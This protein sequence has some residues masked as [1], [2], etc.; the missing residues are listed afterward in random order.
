MTRRVVIDTDPGIDDAIA[1]LAALAHPGLEVAAITTVAGNIGIG[2][3]T[4]NALRILALAGRTVPVHPGASQPLRRSSAD[5]T[6]IHGTDGLGGTAFPEPEAAHSS[7]PAHSAL[8]RLLEDAPEGSL[9]ILALA[10]LTNIARLVTEA[11]DAAR[12]IGRLVVMGGAVHERGNVGARAEF[13][14]AYDP[15]A[16]KIVLSAGLPLTLIALDVTRRV[17]ADAAYLERLAALGTPQ[18]HA[19]RDLIAAY[20]DSTTGGESRPLHDP[21]VPLLAVRP[22]LFEIKPMTLSVDC[23]D[24]EDAGALG[25]GKHALDVAM[26]VDAPTVLDLLAETLGHPAG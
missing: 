9:D 12:R 6:R 19:C 5:E 4:R 2:T 11:P 18:A 17:R 13:N 3:T 10:P 21:C 20:F 1:I 14:I 25:P 22:D 8:R 15:E 23:S 7:E 16:A 26:D 24:G